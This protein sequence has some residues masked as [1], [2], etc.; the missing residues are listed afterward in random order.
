MRI[1]A[2]ANRP[3]SPRS[4]RIP[5]LTNPRKQHKRRKWR[6]PRVGPQFM[7]SLE[8]L[9]G[10]SRERVVLAC[11]DVVT[12]RAKHI[13]GRQ[14]HPLRQSAAGNSPQRR[15]EDGCRRLALRDPA[16]VPVGAPSALVDP[17]GST[18]RARSRRHARRHAHLSTNPC[19][20]KDRRRR[21]ATMAPV[22]SRSHASGPVSGEMTSRRPMEAAAWATTIDVT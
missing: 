1:S 10:L 8:S 17:A 3:R 5:P 20:V 18:G 14:V 21:T 12:G 2:R 13:S 16:R 9:E 15:R 6:D 4:R 11:L 19:Q 7:A 22:S